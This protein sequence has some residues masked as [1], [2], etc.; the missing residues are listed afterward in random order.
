MLA[1]RVY[2]TP[3]AAAIIAAY[4]TAHGTHRANLIIDA[5]LEC[6]VYAYADIHEVVVKIEEL[7]SEFPMG[8]IGILSGCLFKKAKHEIH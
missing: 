6:G 8:V 3:G 7:N 2:P 5:E 4:Q 1:F